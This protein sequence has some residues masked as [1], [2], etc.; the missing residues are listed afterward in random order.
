MRCFIINTNVS[1]DVIMA[2]MAMQFVTIEYLNS[3]NCDN[4]KSN[5]T[6]PTVVKSNIF[7]ILG[8][9]IRRRNILS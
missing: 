9:F 2:T 1:I 8:F 4:I 6:N 3:V 7:S 5:A